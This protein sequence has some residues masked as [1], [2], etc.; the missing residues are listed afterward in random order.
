MSPVC[1][2]CKCST[3][4]EWPQSCLWLAGEL[5]LRAY[6]KRLAERL[7]AP[8]GAPVADLPVQ[9]MDR[10]QYSNGALSGIQ[11]TGAA[12]AEMSGSTVMAY[13]TPVASSGSPGATTVA[14]AQA[15]DK[16]MPAMRKL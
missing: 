8:P 9:R 4:A 2:A 10:Q 14:A 1:A 15:V 3:C 7:S 12:S 16:S 5:F 11:M 6:L 13:G